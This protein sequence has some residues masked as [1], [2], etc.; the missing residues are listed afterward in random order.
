MS[1]ER[2]W[3]KVGVESGNLT[4][5]RPSKL[6]EEDVDSVLVEGT[7]I[8]SMPN[9]YDNS[10]DDFKLEKEDGSA[11]V[12]N[13]AGNLGYRMKLVSPGDYIQ[14]I[15]RGKQEITSGKMKGREAHTFDIMK[16]D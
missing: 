4:F 11:V 15:Y 9:H 1:E 7:F 3:K 13:G 10:R 5:I 14:I 12:I 2:E 8:E 16:S 6:T